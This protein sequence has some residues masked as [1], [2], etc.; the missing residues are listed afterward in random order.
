MTTPLPSAHPGLRP[1]HHLHHL[2]RRRPLVHPGRHPLPPPH[3]SPTML[4]H[5]ALGPSGSQTSRQPGKTW[6]SN[7]PNSPLNPLNCVLAIRDHMHP[8]C[9]HCQDFVGGFVH[10]PNSGNAIILG[11]YGPPTLPKSKSKSGWWFRVDSRWPG[12][13]CLTLFA[14][15]DMR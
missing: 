13:L 15:V 5:V 3:Q 12:Q 9:W 14:T 4:L 7:K 2:G 11:A 8:K 1:L 6:V 10:K